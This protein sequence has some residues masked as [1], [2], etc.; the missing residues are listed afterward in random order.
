MHDVTHACPTC[1]TIISEMEIG[2]GEPIWAKPIW[3][4]LGGKIWILTPRNTETINRYNR[5]N[6]Y[7]YFWMECFGK[8]FHFFH[9]M[10]PVL[11]NFTVNKLKH[12]FKILLWNTL[13]DSLC[14]VPLIV[15]ILYH[16]DI[17]CVSS[18]W[19]QLHCCKWQRECCPCHVQQVG[20]R[21][22]LKL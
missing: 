3:A 14:M 11:C 13:N 4:N 22:R 17:N 16:G 5:Y 7:Y 20:S 1:N 18:T 2:Q 12:S 10:F 6:R 21:F 15:D 9:F 19:V 8:W